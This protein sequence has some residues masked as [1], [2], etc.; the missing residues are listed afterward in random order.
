MM[1]KYLK[2]YLKINDKTKKT[3]LDLIS[4]NYLII[5][6]SF[7][8][9]NLLAFLSVLGSY[10]DLIL[11]VVVILLFY[12]QIVLLFIFMRLTLLLLLSIPLV[13]LLNGVTILVKLI[14]HKL[15]NQVLFKE[16]KGSA[17]V[18]G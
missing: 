6:A 5:L 13:F 12:C 16:V 2:T 8:L 9:V 18:N 15:E 4:L 1:I 11:F 14:D 3:K 17:F 7:F 10:H